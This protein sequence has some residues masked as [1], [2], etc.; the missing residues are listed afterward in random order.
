MANPNAIVSRS[1]RIPDAGR[2]P[3]GRMVTAEGLE[4]ELDDG[5]RIRLDPQNERS[6]GFARVLAG[7]AELKHPVYLEVDPKTDTVARIIVPKVGRVRAV[8]EVEGGIEIELH[9]S[10]AR[11]LLRRD[12]A[13]FAEMEA[14]LRKAEAGHRLLMLSPDD[15]QTIEDL[16]LFKPGPDDGPVPDFPP[17]PETRLDWLD[18]FLRRLRWPWWPRGCVS[19][20]RAQQIFDAM[21]A[22]TCNP[23]GIAP[24]CIPFLYPDDGCWA[25]AHEMRRLMNNMGIYPRKVWIEGNL[26]TPTRNN[27]NC[28]VPWGW[29]VAPTICVRRSWLFWWWPAERKVIDPS[30]F[31]TPVTQAQWKSVQGDPG[32]T[33]TDTDGSIYYMFTNQTDDTYS[34]TNWYLDYYRIA[35]LSRVNQDGPPPYANCP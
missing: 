11:H 14:I 18:W 19:S 26:H 31:T 35:L 13:D 21:S 15:G 2:R 17:F 9:K 3:E 33:L 29:H 1:I 16:R 22:T 28:F 8:R 34:E 10:Q 12:R 6:E 27:P 25:R 23:N 5:R 4:V 32:A 20:W 30:L 7:L 24:P